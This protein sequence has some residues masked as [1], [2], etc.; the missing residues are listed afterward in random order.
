MWTWNFCPSLSSVCSSTCF[1]CAASVIFN[2]FFGGSITALIVTIA[3]V[4]RSHLQ[5]FRQQSTNSDIQAE[6]KQSTNTINSYKF[7]WRLIENCNLKKLTTVLQFCMY[8]MMKPNGHR[9]RTTFFAYRGSFCLHRKC[10]PNLEE[11]KRMSH[12]N[13]IELSCSPPHLHPT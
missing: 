4:N 6:H 12:I 5:S 2:P 3:A 7:A 10:W 11:K 1:T 9:T 13:H 8:C